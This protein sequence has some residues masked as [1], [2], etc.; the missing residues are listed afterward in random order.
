MKKTKT[1]FKRCK[2]VCQTLL[3]YAKNIYNT[4]KTAPIADCAFAA[5][6]RQIRFFCYRVLPF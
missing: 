2:K 1:I 3:L 5:G 4:R 6:Q